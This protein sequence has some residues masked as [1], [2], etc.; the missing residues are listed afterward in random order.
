MAEGWHRVL[1]PLVTSDEN[2]GQCECERA[3][4]KKK[5]TS[6]FCIQTMHP[7]ASFCLVRGRHRHT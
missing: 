3:L 5:F 1:R 7:C 6:Q 4:L 2:L